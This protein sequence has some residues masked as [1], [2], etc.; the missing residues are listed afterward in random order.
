MLILL[1]GPVGS[2]KTTLCRRLVDLA[3]RQGF[4]VAG[5]LT[6]AV[7]RDGIKVGIEAVNLSTGELRRLASNDRGPTQYACAPGMTW[8]GQ[9]VLDDHTLG[10]MAALC[11]EA[12]VEADA[13]A[14]D[15]LVFVDEIG[16]LEL[17]RGEG[18]ARLIP[19]LAQPRQARVIVIVRDTLLDR[20][21]ERVRGAE[22]QVVVVDPQWREDAWVEL[23]RL[24]LA[25]EAGRER[26]RVC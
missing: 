8:V 3:G 24:A 9:Y 23:T 19:L 5:V 20:F 6:P 17:D 11:A 12:L 21:L 10:W 4:Q 2:G 15:S 13:A 14:S 22:C 18:L 26:A 1:S 16:R 25:G 7:V